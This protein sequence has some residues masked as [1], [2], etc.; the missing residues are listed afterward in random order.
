MVQAVILKDPEDVEVQSLARSSPSELLFGPL[1]MALL[2]VWLGMARFGTDE[3][4]LVAAA[5]GIGDGLAP[6]VGES[7]G[8]H[9]YHMP[10]ASRKTMEGS[11]VGVFLGTVVASYVYLYLLGVPGL[12]L[13]MVLMYGGIAA[14]VEGTSP[15]HMDNL[16]VALALHFSMDHILEWLPE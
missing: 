16:T 2:M 9:V 13:R 8:R 3:A 7:F 12:P 14:V 1:Q 6:L 11:V 5:V 10:L 15:G 4:A